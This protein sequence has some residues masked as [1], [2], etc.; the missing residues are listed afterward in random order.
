V[1]GAG[2]HL[3]TGSADLELPLCRRL[4]GV[5]LFADLADF[6]ALS[7]NLARSGPVGIEAL[8]IL[9]NG[10][11]TF[12][13]EGIT[14][15]GGDVTTFA[16][17]ALAAVFV[18]GP[19]G[20]ADCARAAVECA[21][22][23]QVRLRTWPGVPALVPA[24]PDVRIGLGGGE[25]ARAVVGLP[26][27]R[28][29]HVLAGPALDRAVAAQRRARPGAVCV[30]PRLGL[31]DVDARMGMASQH[32]DSSDGDGGPDVW[33]AFLARSSD[34]AHA[35]QDEHRIVTTAFVRLP[36][37]D[38]LDGGIPRLQELVA[39]ALPVIDSFGGDL[40]QVDAGDKGYQL[41]LGFGAPRS[42]PDD[43]ERAAA[44]ALSLV[45][46]PGGPFSVGLATG[47][48]FCGEVGHDQRREYVV[49]GSSV[50]LAARLAQ[51]A[52]PGQVRMD[53]PTAART[54]GVTSQ[55]LLGLL[56]VK[57]HS[58]PVEVHA[59]TGL[60]EP[61]QVPGT[62]PPTQVGAFVGRR[63]ELALARRRLGVAE[64]GQGQVLLV[65]GE[66]G[67]GKSRLCRQ[68]TSEAAGGW[69]HT[70]GSGW[71]PGDVRPYLAWREIIRALVPAALGEPSL[72]AALGA[73]PVADER[74]PLLGPVLG[75][76]L[77]D[78]DFTAS[79]DP[80][81][82]AHT[83]RVLILDL[84]RR[85]T[86]D[87]PVA[88]LVDDCHWLDE[89]SRELLEHLAANIADLPVLIVA[90]AREDESV[91]QL[92]TR[93][94]VLAHVTHL[95]LRELP[96]AE[97]DLLVRDRLE[98]GGLVADSAA[99]DLRRIVERGGGNPLFL[100][101]LVGYARE[102]GGDWTEDLPLDVRRL[103]LARVD[104]L[105]PRR[106]A[107][108][109]TASVVG[110][111]FSA[112]AITAC[113][114]EVGSRGQVRRHLD[115]LESLGLI[116]L[117]GR[118]PEPTYDFAHSL[119][120]EVVYDSIS[121]N[122]RTSL[123][124][125]VGRY[126]ENVHAG[127]EA[128]WAD[129]VAFHYGRGA[130]IG[131][132][133]QWFRIAGDTSRQAYA[134]E[135]ALRYYTRL[136]QI[137]PDE[138]RPCILVALGALRQLTG[139]WTDA[140]TAL[141]E[142]VSAASHAEDHRV[143]AD[144]ERELGILLLATRQ[145]PEAVE[146]L[147]AAAAA[148]TVLADPNALCQA[149]DR[150]AFALFEHGD[151]AAALEVAQ[152]QLAVQSS[153]HDQAGMSAALLNNALIAWHTGDHGEALRMLRTAY[154][155]ARRSGDL[156]ATVHVANDLAG[157]Y[158][159]R[160]NH[161]K[162]VQHLQVAIRTAERIG[163]RQALGY[164]TG[165][166]GELYRDR[167]A[168]LEANRCFAAGLTSALAIGDW[169]TTVRCVGALAV[170]AAD[171][172]DA[173][174]DHYLERAA[175]IAGILHQSY[176]L[177]DVALRRAQL[178]WD[179]GDLARAASLAQAAEDAALRRSEPALVLRPRLLR[180]RAMVALGQLDAADAVA[181][182]SAALQDWPEPPERALLLDTIA[183]VDPRLS[184]ASAEAAQLYRRLYEQAP[185]SSYADAYRR[186]TG[187]RLPPAPELPPLVG[188]L[189]DVPLDLG[190]LLTRVEQL[191][192]DSEAAPAHS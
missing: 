79:L 27:L 116:A 132:Q 71:A 141:R 129:L 43:A 23:L 180:L 149:L 22:T 40:R 63:D 87:R 12:M 106:Q 166:A 93:L 54:G 96:S 148:Y 58:T 186:L 159:D 183:Q 100:E 162:A 73:L 182:V 131:K 121:R 53:G 192:R 72:S 152:R 19:E 119:V 120:Q 13:I 113:L 9:I 177:T 146:R 74:A 140:E 103:V 154:V 89:L 181:E 35:L 175:S 145:H 169:I 104:R 70:A 184:W 3:A 5:V 139:A 125:A 45:R 16:G 78:N 62:P 15:A 77:P 11:F 61:Q 30:D 163:Y 4:H 21:R 86:G 135:A 7:E 67:I 138:E 18:D 82:R 109:K 191:A 130:D 47:P 107:T 57:G 31:D 124:E 38:P 60:R 126:L 157:L 155:L 69:L 48:A 174:A 98:A 20:R 158:A 95:S 33:T 92:S 90:V 108:I 134:N 34:G 118:D 172:G 49:I 185:G 133:R 171:L 167:G 36:N 26:R 94:R 14:A 114:P 37:V 115:E 179:R 156:R 178:A 88:V 173:H 10:Y 68:I 127:D 29:R 76:A 51:A 24:R 150:L 168:Y 65:T 56:T 136:L 32:R 75:I 1:T 165:N 161:R 6:T 28:L 83:T 190:A 52:E 151:L 91:R 189:D 42:S 112:E 17:D 147:R 2:F 142:A 59:V 105:V 110:E 64:N 50:N 99:E 46:L 44:C 187:R 84:L 41:V 25:V 170:T 144:A 143:L 137:A 153:L 8:S 122:R 128:A 66:P 80:G 123:H 97:A 176:I 39:S 188:V 55:Q 164:L 160:G 117:R 85:C 111:Q 81:T 101:Q 102:R